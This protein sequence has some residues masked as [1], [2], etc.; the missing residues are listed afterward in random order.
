MKDKIGWLAQLCVLAMLTAC[1]PQAMSPQID[2]YNVTDKTG[3]YAQKVDNF[4]II[5]DAS[6][7]LFDQYNGQQKFTAAHDTVTRL[8]QTIPHL[9]MHSGLRVYGPNLVPFKG[10]NTLIHGMTTYDTDAM[11]GAIEEIRGTAGTSPLS[12]ALT[13]AAD[14]L[15]GV[16][17]NL[18]II[19]ITD[20]LVAERPTLAAATSLH[21]KFGDRLCIYPILIGDSSTGRATLEKVVQGIGCGFVRNAAQLDTP[22]TMAG[23]VTEIFYGM[24]QDRDGDGVIDGMDK[25][26]NT[27]EGDAVGSDGCPLDADGDGVIDAQDKCPNTP[28]GIKVN[29][30]GCAYLMSRPMT[31]N[32]HIEFDTNKSVVKLDYY[33]KIQEFADFLKQHPDTTAII[34]AHTD[35]RGS[36]AYN[37]KLSQARADSVRQYMIKNFNT[38]PARLKA[39]GYGFSH[40]IAD[41]DT[42]E[43]RR[44]NRRVDVVVSKTIK[45]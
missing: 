20:A 16:D 43:G 17:G 23:Y 7:S 24:K 15:S 1:T 38:A 5:F 6:S 28:R 31:I 40:P 27:P 8:N 41:N 44:R 25:C 9:D 4:L 42:E 18:A 32:L 14:D 36:E 35:N 45:R 11:Q 21:D 19:L 10:Y 30:A 33:K 26:P 29:A 22:E 39:I 37:Q 34:G 2:A 12:Q 3:T 13:L